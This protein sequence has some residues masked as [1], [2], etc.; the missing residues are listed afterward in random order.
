MVSQPAQLHP[1][2]LTSVP[3]LD[4]AH[5]SQAGQIIFCNRSSGKKLQLARAVLSSI[6][7]SI[8]CQSLTEEHQKLAVFLV[9][10]K[11]PVPHRMLKILRC[12]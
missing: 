5:C 4:L 11:V 10:M 2:Q 12:A 1:N 9:K 3:D 8:G 6:I 7:C